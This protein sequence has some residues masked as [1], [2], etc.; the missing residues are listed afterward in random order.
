MFMI[1]LAV[2]LVLI[3][4]MAPLAVTELYAP[5]LDVGTSVVTSDPWSTLIASEGTTAAFAYG[6]VMWVASL[7]MT[8]V[9]KFTVLSLLYTY[10]GFKFQVQHWV[11]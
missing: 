6:Y 4:C 7:P 9:A 8:L 10:G 2:R 5:F 3:V 1:G 11:D